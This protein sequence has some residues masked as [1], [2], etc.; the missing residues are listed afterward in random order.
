MGSSVLAAKFPVLLLS[1]LLLGSRTRGLGHG[2]G[3]IFWSAECPAH[4]DTRAAGLKGLEHVGFRK[5]ILIQIDSE[6]LGQRLA[7]FRVSRPHREDDQ[8]K[9]ILFARLLFSYRTRSLPL[10][11]S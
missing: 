8:I 6:H 9:I 7:V 10:S 11:I 1:D 2:V 3:I 4:E 5:T